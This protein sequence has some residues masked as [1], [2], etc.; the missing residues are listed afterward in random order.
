MTITFRRIRM[1]VS[2][3]YQ[4]LKMIARNQILFLRVRLFG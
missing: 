2:I 3:R 1:D 4:L